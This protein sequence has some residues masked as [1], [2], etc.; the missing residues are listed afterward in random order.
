MAKTSHVAVVGSANIDLTTFNDRWPRGGETIFGDSFDLGF[1]GKGANQA[2]AAKLCGADVSMVARVGDDLFGPST[3]ENFKSQ[4]INAEHV[5]IVEGISSGVA[6]IFVDTA[7]G[8]NRILVIPGAN[9][10]VLPA[11]V[12][13]AGDM[14]KSA[15]CIVLQ[16]E[17]P[18]ETVYHTIRFAHENGIRC[19]LNPAPGQAV[20]MDKVAN[21]DYFVPNET[22]A[23]AV[24]GIAV[25]SVDDA[26]RCAE[27]LLEAGIKRVIITLGSQGSLV[28]GG[29]GMQHVPA[30]SVEAVDT[31]GA[32][33]AFIGSFAV[34]L[35]EGM[36]EIEAV[37]RANLYAGLSTTG[38]G[39]QKSF[40]DRAAFDAAWA[41][42][43][44]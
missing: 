21:L 4:G 34:F 43:S 36:E 25:G 44:R 7:S 12:D 41:E 28:A 6:P 38:V 24:T 29:D 3:I 13:A 15:D 26:K 39:T 30:F 33:D 37:T 23:E 17:I 18:L 42:R 2:V 1:G 31:T 19:I 35:G 5:R 32:G 20:E 8:Q 11:D 40:L 27:K 14:L 10:K 22:E 16:F 9:N